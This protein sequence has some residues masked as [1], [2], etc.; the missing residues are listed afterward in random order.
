[1]KKINLRIGDIVVSTEPVIM[2]TV[3]GSCVSVCLWDTKSGI[4]GM[5]H[6]MFPYVIDKIKDPAYCGT[7][8]INMLIGEFHKLGACKAHLKAKVFGGGKVMKEISEHFYIGA[9]NI[10]IAKKIL[11]EHNIPIVKEFTGSDCGTKVIFHSNTGRAFIKMLKTSNNLINQ[12]KFAIS[13]LD[14]KIYN[15]GTGF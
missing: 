3:L 14:R 12:G 1:M 7:E 13:P 15:N 11:K 8:S 5:N 4:G 6:F 9:E 2:E 10:R